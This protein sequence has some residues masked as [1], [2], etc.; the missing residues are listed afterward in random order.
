MH[1]N[2]ANPIDA[3]HARACRYCHFHGGEISGG[4]WCLQSKQ[5]CA[6]GMGCVFFEREPGSDD[7][8]VEIRPCVI[9]KCK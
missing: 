3:Q 1:A 6:A 2:F 7:D 8:R 5:V 4:V 9:A